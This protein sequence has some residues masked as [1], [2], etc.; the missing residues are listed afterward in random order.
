MEPGQR[1]QPARAV[2]PSTHQLSSEIIG[3]RAVDAAL[4]ASQALTGVNRRLDGR[5]L[6]ALRR[7]GAEDL[8]PFPDRPRTLRSQSA[9][10]AA[11]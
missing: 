5:S 6:Y 11:R 8:L 7:D 3:R 9:G 4:D 2:L 10:E 1:E